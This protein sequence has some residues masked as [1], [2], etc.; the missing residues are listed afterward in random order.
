MRGNDQI[1]NMQNEVNRI[2]ET[3]FS[4]F[5]HQHYYYNHFWKIPRL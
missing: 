1:I 4:Q 5:F 2:E 3:L